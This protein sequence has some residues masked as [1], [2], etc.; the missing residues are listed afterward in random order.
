M[1][2]VPGVSRLAEANNGQKNSNMVKFTDGN[3]YKKWWDLFMSN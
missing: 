1:T 2:I 3:N